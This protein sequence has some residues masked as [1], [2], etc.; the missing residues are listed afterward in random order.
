MARRRYISTTMSKDKLLNR[1]AMECGDFAVLLYTWLIPHAD[2]DCT[3]PADPEEILYEVMPGRRDKTPADIQKAVDFMVKLGLLEYSESGK[4]RE[5]PESFYKYQTYIKQSNR[6]AEKAAQNIQSLKNTAKHRKTPENTA[7]FSPSFPVPI[8]H[9]P[10]LSLRENDSAELASDPAPETVIS[11]PL[12][13]GDQFPINQNQIDG[14][15]QLYPAVDVAQE[16]REM[17]G[18]CDANPRRRKTKGGIL[19]FINGWLAREQDHSRAAPAPAYQK[20][21][22]RVTYLDSGGDYGGADE[23]SLNRV[24]NHLKN[25]EASGDAK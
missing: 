25:K 22:K 18:W 9:S 13:T 12:N 14:W 8:S 21:T 17:K 7:S 4:L 10:S 2:D 20:K 6:T 24:K 15:Q 11:L 5:K 19:V 23:E 1:L 3:L 16:L